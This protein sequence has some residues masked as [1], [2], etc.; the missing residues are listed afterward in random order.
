MGFLFYYSW[1]ISESYQNN[2]TDTIQGMFQS[3]STPTSHK[4]SRVSW[5]VHELIIYMWIYNREI[6]ADQRI[7][8]NIYLHFFFLQTHCMHVLSNTIWFISWKYGR[9]VPFN[10]FSQ[11]F[12]LPS[13][14]NICFIYLTPLLSHMGKVFNISQSKGQKFF[15]TVY[16]WK[17]KT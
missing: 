4:G 15:N 3:V 2:L 12:Q 10:L 1:W 9:Y 5:L 7:L 16:F 13:I 14:C 6:T 17:L 8:D 11:W